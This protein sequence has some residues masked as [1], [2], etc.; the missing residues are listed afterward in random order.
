[1]SGQRGSLVALFNEMTNSETDF[2]DFMSAQKYPS[3]LYFS[4]NFYSVNIHCFLISSSATIITT[5]TVTLAGLLR[6]VTRGGQGAAWTVDPSSA[7]VRLF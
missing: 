4:V 6:S 3:L 2:K 5:A 7:R 1:M